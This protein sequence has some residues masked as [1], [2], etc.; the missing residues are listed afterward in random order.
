MYENRFLGGS[1][2]AVTLSN[3]ITWQ[4]GIIISITGRSIIFFFFGGVDTVLM[5]LSI[6]LHISLDE[7]GTF[8]FSRDP[9][10]NKMMHVT[11]DSA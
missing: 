1:Q 9:S 3:L 5:Y 2:E 11:I 10:C 7:I 4:I 6:Y 8:Y